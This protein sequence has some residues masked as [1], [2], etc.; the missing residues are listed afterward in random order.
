[1]AFLE[2][3]LYFLYTN[4][5]SSTFGNYLSNYDSRVNI[6]IDG[7]IYKYN[8]SDL[9]KTMKTLLLSFYITKKKSRSEKKDFI[10]SYIARMGGLSFRW[11]P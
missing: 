4:Q 8:C 7:N 9:M 3:P 10:D 2:V 11:R 1:M 5:H 6:I